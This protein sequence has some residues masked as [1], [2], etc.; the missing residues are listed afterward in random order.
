MAD[1]RTIAFE[2]SCQNVGLALTLVTL[3]FGKNRQDRILYNQFPLAFSLFMIV[4]AIGLVIIIKIYQI[5][6]ERRN[7]QALHQEKEPNDVEKTAGEE[8]NGK[9]SE[10]PHS[11]NGVIIN[12][13]F[14]NDCHKL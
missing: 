6:R 10:I 5:C 4:E 2:T 14:T 3:A 12:R 11:E 9:I 8:S 13:A 1:R 7:K